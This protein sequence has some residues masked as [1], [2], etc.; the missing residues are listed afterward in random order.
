SQVEDFEPGQME[1][2]VSHSAGIVDLAFLTIQVFERA[3]ARNRAKH[4]ETRAYTRPVWSPR[5]ENSMTGY[6]EY[7]ARSQRGS[8]PGIPA[9]VVRR[10]CIRIRFLMVVSLETSSSTK[11]L[12]RC[13]A[14]RFRP[15]RARGARCR[16]SKACGTLSEWEERSD[17]SRPLEPARIARAHAR[18]EAVD[19][20]AVS[21]R[22]DGGGAVAV[23]R[24]SPQPAK[25]E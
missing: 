7:E 17:L 23:R 5:F 2:L 11:S 6:T 10:G 1:R 19:Q 25:V 4:G 21:V 15:S 14:R 16:W 22:G 13:W 20:C 9:R 18:A 3:S 12:A 24:S 8:G